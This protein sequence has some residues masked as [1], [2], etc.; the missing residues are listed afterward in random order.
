MDT[1][2]IFQTAGKQYLVREGDNVLLEKIEEAE[3]KTITFSEVL[4]AATDK[5]VKIG[6]P[7]LVGAKVEAK[8]LEHGRHPKVFGVK[9][10]AKKREK[11]YF[12]HKQHY[13][14]IQITKITTK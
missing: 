10:K 6:T 9:M 2:T 4:L 5:N 12:G 8:I 11:K 14:K 13:T 7:L 1:L 3:G